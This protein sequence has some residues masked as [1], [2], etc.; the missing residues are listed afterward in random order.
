MIYSALVLECS[1]DSNVHQ[2]RYILSLA[3]LQ[4]LKTPYEA[5]NTES[6]KAQDASSDD[7][8]LQIMSVEVT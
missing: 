2:M 7:D 5:Q 6:G 3:K 4:K 8:D 1:C